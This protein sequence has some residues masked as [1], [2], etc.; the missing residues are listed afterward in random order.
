MV[1]ETRHRVARRPYAALFTVCLRCVSGRALLRAFWALRL[2]GRLPRCR[3]VRS[4]D[5]LVGGG[6]P[7]CGR[8]A[9]KGATNADKTPV[10]VSIGPYFT[11]SG[12]TGPA[13]PAEGTNYDPVG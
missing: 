5:R 4:L 3:L 11:H 13:G 12:Q 10:I 8:V 9:P 2:G 7:S 1:W 6:H